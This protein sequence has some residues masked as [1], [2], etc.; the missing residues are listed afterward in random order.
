ML[1]MYQARMAVHIL[2]GQTLTMMEIRFG[3]S[4]NGKWAMGM[5]NISKE[6]SN[7]VK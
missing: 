3:R 4:R 6:D 5:D 2:S 1:G 7:Q